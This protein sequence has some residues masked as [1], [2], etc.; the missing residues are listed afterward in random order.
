[1]AMISGALGNEA[2][3]TE[4]AI[5]AAAS[6]LSAFKNQLLSLHDR[7]DA[8]NARA[9][10]DPPKPDGKVGQVRTVAMG[11]IGNLIAT[12]DDIGEILDRHTNAVSRL[13]GI[14]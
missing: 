10:G 14:V 5:Q 3:L 6:R 13:S 1:M 9:F 7:V 2:A 12:M 11:E 8:V 4:S